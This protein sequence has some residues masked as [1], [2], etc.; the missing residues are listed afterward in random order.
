MCLSGV[1]AIA[2]SA[3]TRGGRAPV[4]LASLQRANLLLELLIA[5]LQLL[6]RAGELAQRRLEAVDAGQKVGAWDICARAASPHSA[7]N[8]ATTTREME[9]IIT[10]N[11]FA[12]WRLARS[13]HCIWRSSIVTD[14][15]TVHFDHLDL[16]RASKL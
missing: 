10:G 13:L 1:A 8:S 6:H 12:E 7:H 2:R 15:E 5:V 4:W 14:L 16:R 9:R 3:A 11:F